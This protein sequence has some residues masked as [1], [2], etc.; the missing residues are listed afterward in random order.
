[1][2]FE[3]YPLYIPI[4]PSKL[5]LRDW[6]FVTENV[7]YVTI[8]TENNDEVLGQIVNDGCYGCNCGRCI[9]PTQEISAMELSPIGEIANEI[10]EQFSFFLYDVKIPLFVVMPNHIHLIMI[11]K[12][13]KNKNALSVICRKLQEIK[14][15]ITE[16]TNTESNMF[17]EHELIT[18]IISTEMFLQIKHVIDRNRKNW[19]LDPLYS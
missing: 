3:P 8:K 14:L 7:F 4:L 2:I 11:V 16:R 17:D 18:P 6:D 1:M 19:R 9:D 5:Q 10:I 15:K 13:N 12:N